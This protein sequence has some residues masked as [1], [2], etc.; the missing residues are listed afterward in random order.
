MPEPWFPPLAPLPSPSGTL[1][2]VLARDTETL[3]LL[4]YDGVADRR[5]AHT[6]TLDAR[7]HRKGEV[8]E[9][10]VEGAQQPGQ[11]AAS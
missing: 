10:L 9:V 1:F 5:P 4:L 8:F 6:R 7:T 11:Q 2:R 3:H